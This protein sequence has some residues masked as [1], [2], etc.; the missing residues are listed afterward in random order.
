VQQLVD[1][2]L[3][4]GIAPD[5]V[6]VMTHYR[7]QLFLLKEQL[8]QYG[9]VEMHTTDRFQ[10]RDKEV[11]VLSLVRSN[12]SCSIGDL[13][14]DWRRINVAFTRAKTKLIVVG[15][16]RTLKNS[17]DETMPL[18]SRLCDSDYRDWT[19]AEDAQSVRQKTNTVEKD[20][21]RR[22]RRKGK[23]ASDA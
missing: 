15:S 2:L 14:K 12:D 23:H 13:L 3:T 20:S 8:R 4:V 21:W 9:G 16:K 11:I 6:G 19:N 17:G 5:E 22:R 1:S 7:A 18:F 10:G